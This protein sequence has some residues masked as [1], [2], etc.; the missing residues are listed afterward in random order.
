MTKPVVGIIMGSQSDLKVMRQAAEFLEEMKILSRSRS[1]RH[2]A[3]R[4][5]WFR[6]PPKRASVV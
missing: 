5:A 6:M 3:R 1:Y 4:H 2:I